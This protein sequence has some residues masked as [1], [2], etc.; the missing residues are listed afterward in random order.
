MP[1]EQRRQRLRPLLR[2]VKCLDDR[3]GRLYQ[4]VDGDG[5]T[6]AQDDDYR[7]AGRRGEDLARQVRLP[8]RQQRVL[9][10]HALVLLGLV[11][12][13]GQDSDVRGRS[14]GRGCGHATRVA[15]GDAGALHE[16]RGAAG[17]DGRQVGEDGVGVVKACGLVVR[18]QQLGG[19]A[20]RPHHRDLLARLERQ[21]TLRILQ[22]HHLHNGRCFSCQQRTRT[23]LEKVCQSYALKRR[24]SPVSLDRLTS[25]YWS[26]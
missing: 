17:V 20:H 21:G 22:Q 16:G 6:V 19:I 13:N 9:A 7:L 5:A 26:C 18:E 2:R 24:L 23:Q 11:Q 4:V 12:P 14:C 8:R 3:S 15:A 1:E 10:V 25:A